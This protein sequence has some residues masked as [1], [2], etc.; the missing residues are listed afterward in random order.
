MKAAH[1]R[2]RHAPTGAPWRL[3]AALDAGDVPRRWL[4][5]E[6]ARRRAVGAR[7][8]LAHDRVLFRQAVTTLDDHLARGLRV[9]ALGE[10]V[11]GFEVRGDDDDAV[12]RDK[13]LVFGSP[14]F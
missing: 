7:P 8:P 14:V 5:L 11:D 2:E 13:D 4:D 12:L 6:V 3:V 10:L 9:A 1:V